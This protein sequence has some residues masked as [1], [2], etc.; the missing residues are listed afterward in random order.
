MDIDNIEVGDVLYVNHHVADPELLNAEVDPE[1]TDFL[2]RSAQVEV[3]EVR[4]E[5][6]SVV[7]TEPISDRPHRWLIEIE[8]L[9]RGPSSDSDD[10]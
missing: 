8:Q 10:K 5:T 2:D 1:S 3:E 6:G 9:L 7:V 4:K